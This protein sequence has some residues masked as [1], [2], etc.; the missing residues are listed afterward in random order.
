ME[1]TGKIIENNIKKVLF[2]Q[3]YL[4]FAVAMASS[5]I[6]DTELTYQN[7]C[8]GLMNSH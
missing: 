2:D 4:K 7:I 6:V 5:Q 3:T 8:K 1:I